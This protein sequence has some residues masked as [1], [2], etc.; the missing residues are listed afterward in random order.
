MTF[1]DHSR[2]RGQHAF[3]SASKYSWINYDPDKLAVSRLI[4]RFWQSLS[5]TRVM[6]I[7][8]RVTFSLW[9]TIIPMMGAVRFVSCSLPQ[10]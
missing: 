1:N 9:V 5:M 3:L 2:L 6:P 10:A 8:I 4:L 7:S